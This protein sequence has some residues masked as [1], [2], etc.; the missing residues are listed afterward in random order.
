MT[1]GLDLGTSGV[2]AVALQA[3]GTL[4]AQAHA[5]L[6][7]SRPAPL[8][9]EQDPADWWAATDAAVNALRAQLAPAAWARVRALAVAGQMHGAVLLDAQDQTLRPAILWNDGRAQAQCA[10]LEVRAPNSREDTGNV[11]MAG[12]TAPK[13]L[14]V[15]AHE[16]AVFERLDRVLLPKDWLVLQLTGVASSE[17]SD[18]AGTLWLDLARRDWSDEQ[19]KATGLQRRHMPVLHESAQVV[20]HLLPQWARAWGLSPAV[21]VAAGAGDN[22]AAALGLGVLHPGQGL[23]SL[24]TSGVIF[25]PTAQPQPHPARGVHAFCHARP[26]TWHQ[27]A[28]HLNAASVL[29]WWA[30]VCGQP[31][32]ALLAELDAAALDPAAELPLCLP[33]LSGERTPHADPAASGAFLGLRASHG[34]AD[35]TQAVLEGVA[36]ALADGLDALREAGARPEALLATGGGARSGRWLQVLADVL[37]LPLQRP[38]AAEVGPALGAARLALCSLGHAEAAVMAPPAIEQVFEPRPAAARAP[39]LARRARFQAAWAPL[40]A[41]G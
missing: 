32:A 24:G 28:V 27:M 20:G 35:M 31:V 1:L 36:F 10:E 29:A 5:A 2:K 37:D 33:Y 23:V 22:A 40:R 8:W 11:A 9:S 18:A 30:E 34:R 12:F 17:P 16:P 25:L 38:L 7:V 26:H 15:A 39:L 4:L 21:H 14:W 13:L 3:D 41:L 6:T 19:L